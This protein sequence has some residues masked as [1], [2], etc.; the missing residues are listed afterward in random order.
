VSSACRIGRRGERLK[1]LEQFSQTE[2]Q[3]LGSEAGMTSNNY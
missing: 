3:E 1:E 2:L